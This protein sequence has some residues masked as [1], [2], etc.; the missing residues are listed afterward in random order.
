MLNRDLDR[1]G[2]EVRQL[3]R[4]LDHDLTDNQKFLIQTELQRLSGKSAEGVTPAQIL[5]FYCSD[6]SK[7]TVLHNL[8]LISRG[9]IERIDH[10]VISCFFDVFVLNSTCFY[11]DLKISVD[12]EYKLFD[13]REYQPIISP[14]DKCNRQIKLLST[15]FNDDI[16]LPTRVG[17]PVR[18]R[19]QAVILLS[20]SQGVIRPPAS[21]LDTSHVIAANQFIHKLLRHQL[22]AR[23]NLFK[24]G[25]LARFCSRSTLKRI[26]RELAALHQPACID[27]A[28]EI[29]I[30]QGV[31]QPSGPQRPSESL[32]AE[33]SLRRSFR[34]KSSK[35]DPQ[36]AVNECGG[37]S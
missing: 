13:G 19:L 22:S 18:P 15:V 5:D 34:R 26:A 7:W 32:P 11:H 30:D 2:K 33:S 4:M 8:K 23:S 3:K 17:V 9:G 1:G 36:L 10:L 37:A 24:L 16:P 28:A 6:E 20:P 35:S 21:V 31:C 27:F 29:G 25:L 14:A 12:G